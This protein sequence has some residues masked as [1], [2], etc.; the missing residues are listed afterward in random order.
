MS[1]QGSL[2]I[3]LHTHLPF[4]RHPEHPEFLEERWLFEAITETYLPLLERFQRLANERVPF[5]ITM[6]FTPP[7]LAMLGDGLL[8]TR[9]LRHLEKLIELADKEIQRTR[10]MPPFHRLALF[11]HHRL[12]TVRALYATV[13]RRNLIAP[14]REL[15]ERGFLEPIASAATH[16]FLPLMNEQPVAA[17]AQIAVGVQAF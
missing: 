12:T 8:Q 2:A 3:V 5:R 10:W 15:S 4:V 13:Y 9:Y 14:F 16:G 1:P 7:L 17:R 6:S 11:Y